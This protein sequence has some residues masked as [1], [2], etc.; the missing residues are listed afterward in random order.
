MPIECVA[1]NNIKF[2]CW[3]LHVS[4][5]HQADDIDE[6]ER[7]TS[8]LNSQ[9]NPLRHLKNKS[10]KSAQEF[11]NNNQKKYYLFE[12]LILISRPIKHATNLWTGKCNL[13]DFLINLDW[14]TYWKIIW[15]NRTLNIQYSWQH[16]N[17]II[18]IRKNNHKLKWT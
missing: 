17:P 14:I 1:N 2:S 10:R 13:C 3:F 16:K 8:N 15:V 12:S 18:I 5:W 7:K 9:C 11:W 4:C 6:R